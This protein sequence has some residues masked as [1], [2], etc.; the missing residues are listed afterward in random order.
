MKRERDEYRPRDV[1]RLIEVALSDG[2]CFPGDPEGGKDHYGFV[3]DN[4]NQQT[5]RRV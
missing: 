4:G 1:F 2:L 3:G 5:R